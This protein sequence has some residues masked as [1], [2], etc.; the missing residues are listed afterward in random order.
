MEDTL[1]VTQHS[2]RN[3]NA[4]INGGKMRK[5]ERM[6]N[7]LAM[8]PDDFPVWHY[9]YLQGNCGIYFSPLFIHLLNCQLTVSSVILKVR[10]FLRSSY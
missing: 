3:N 6:G 8:S 9:Y 2:P 5:F 10:Y 4:E 1:R 7:V